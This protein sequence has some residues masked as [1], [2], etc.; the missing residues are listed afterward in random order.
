MEEEEEEEVV[1]PKA[2]ASPTGRE[3]PPNLVVSSLKASVR[4]SF[5]VNKTS[6]ADT[7][8]FTGMSL[9]APP[10][11]PPRLF[12][13]RSSSWAEGEMSTGGQSDYH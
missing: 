1:A 3:T 11:S 8:S 4:S 5:L 7:I 12:A 6:S 10:S 2:F 13:A 9:D